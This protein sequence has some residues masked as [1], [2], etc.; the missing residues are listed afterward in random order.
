VTVQIV[1][2]PFR[3]REKNCFYKRIELITG[4]ELAYLEERVG[5]GFVD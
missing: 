2:L 3:R 4:Q 5:N 1:K